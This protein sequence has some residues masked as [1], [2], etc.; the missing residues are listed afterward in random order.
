[1]AETDLS[2]SLKT[3]FPLF[4]EMPQLKNPLPKRKKGNRLVM[5]FAKQIGEL[6]FDKEPA[7]LKLVQ[8]IC[9]DNNYK[10]R[11]D[12]VGFFK[13][14]LKEPSPAILAHPRFKS[15]Y[16]SELLELLQD[17]EAYIRIEALDIIT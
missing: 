7:V 9:H 6:G 4:S 17:E 11:M 5:S 10:I 15:V 13:D 3:V 12:G 1:V 8:A 16:I 14:Y 2:F